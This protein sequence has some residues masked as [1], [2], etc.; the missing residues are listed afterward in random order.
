MC[1][2]LISLVFLTVLFGLPLG[3]ALLELRRG[4]AV[5]I[6]G[7]A[8]AFREQRRPE[9][10][11]QLRKAS[12]VRE[13]WVPRY[14]EFLS[15]VLGRGNE[16]AIEGRAQ[17]LFYADDLDLI[18]GPGFMRPGQAGPR[19]VEIIVGFR[20][21]LRERGIELLVVPVPLKGMVDSELLSKPRPASVPAELA[22]APRNPDQQ[23]FF[24]AL[25]EQGVHSLQLL[26]LFL[27]AARERSAAGQPPSGPPSE[28]PGVFLP[29]DTHW[30]PELM[31]LSAARIA[32]RVRE[33]LTEQSPSGA[34]AAGFAIG[35]QRV[36]ADGDL[37]RMLRLPEGVEVWKPMQLVVHPVLDASGARL[38]PDP[39]ADVLLLGDS[40]TRVFS[41]PE[42][43]LGEGAGLAEQLAAKLGRPIDSIALL[44]GSATAVRETLARRAG[45]LDGKRLVVWEFGMRAL[46]EG[47][48]AWGDVVLPS[49]GRGASQD[50]GQPGG[51]AGESGEVAGQPLVVEARLVAACRIPAEFDYAFCLVIHE[52]AVER[53]LSGALEA[54]SIWVA[55][56][57]MVD[58]E[59]EAPDSWS[60]GLRQRLT[61]EDLELHHS[62]EETSYVDANAPLD[63][64]IYWA[65]ELTELD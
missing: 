13:S 25:D 33:L 24:A 41:D 18:T 39:Q 34:R 4:E 27:E 6:L 28:D 31:E 43:G 42:L 53:T 40:F 58:Y 56:P 10:E 3:Q 1:K 21:A 32:S 12:F 55:F 30:R 54:E 26:P 48:G 16:K 19:A 64:P 14:Q 60:A 62:L 23:A 17:S 45:G 57:G 61:L 44:G 35:E 7:L 5:G 50:P 52:Y 47:P 49:Q 36:R 63:Q 38:G 29:R 20:D 59:R 2:R 22:D 8:E 15:R 65:V 46:G 51:G 37:V 11:E 9:F